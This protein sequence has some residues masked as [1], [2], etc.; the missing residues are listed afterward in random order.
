[1]AGTHDSWGPQIQGLTRS[2]E[3]ADDEPARADE[4]AGA[5]AADG[6]DGGDGI[7]VCCFDNRGVGRSSAPPHKSNYS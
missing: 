4:E 7:E 5:G 1:L 6:E 2:L 3:P